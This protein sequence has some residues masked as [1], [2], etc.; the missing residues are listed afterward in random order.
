M[1][2]ISLKQSYVYFF[3]VSL[4][5]GVHI[6]ATPVTARISPSAPPTQSLSSN[7]PDITGKSF[8]VL[9]PQVTGQ[10]NLQARIQAHMPTSRDSG[11]LVN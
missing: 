4:E 2:N 10:Y 11:L 1:E 3:T 7:L 6:T 9:T 8:Q 5:P